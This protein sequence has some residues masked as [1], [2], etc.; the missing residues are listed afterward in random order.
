VNR[1]AVF[2]RPP[3]PGRV[4]TRLSPALPARLAAE[5]SAALLADTL[6]AARA[7]AAGE[8][9]LWWADPPMIEAAPSGFTVRLQS[10][11]G[12]G[13]RLANATGV[14]LAEPGDRVVVIASDLPAIS[15]ALL[16]EAF[17]SLDD[18]DLV[19]GPAADGGYWLI[20]LTRPAPGLFEGIAWST[21]EVVAQSLAAAANAGLKTHLLAKLDDIDTPAN[22]ARLVAAAATGRA[23][24]VGPKAAGALRRMGMLPG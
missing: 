13:E 6:D 5:L 22:L 19:L 24:V 15:A 2:A 23:G 12:L 9:T 17:A 7:C 11:T 16:D 3:V 14:L 4:K 20:G 10:G 18:H 1:I 21:D 8:R